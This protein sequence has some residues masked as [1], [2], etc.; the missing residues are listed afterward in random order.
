[1]TFQYIN[2]T[3]KIFVHLVCSV[4]KQLDGINAI[5]LTIIQ[6]LLLILIDNAWLSQQD[7]ISLK[8]MALIQTDQT[9]PSL[10][11][12]IILMI[13]INDLLGINNC[14]QN[15]NYPSLFYD[16]FLLFQFLFFSCSVQVLF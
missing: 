12:I 3:F 13:I 9:K 1:L 11:Q 8:A 6:M 10:F 16:Y 15:D 2:A 7:A 5:K 4:S 14:L